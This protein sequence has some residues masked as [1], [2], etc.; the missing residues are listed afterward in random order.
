MTPEKPVAGG[1]AAAKPPKVRSVSQTI[2]ISGV[3][4]DDFCNA[5]EEFARG[6]AP[7]LRGVDW[8]ELM[9]TEGRIELRSAGQNERARWSSGRWERI[10]AEFEAQNG[11]EVDPRLLSPA[12]RRA[13]GF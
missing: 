7:T 11:A 5:I 2:S 9:I 6:E 13:C 10:Q 8:Q 4:L 1:S 12:A 3:A